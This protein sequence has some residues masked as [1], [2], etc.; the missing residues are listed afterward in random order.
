MEAAKVKSMSITRGEKLVRDEEPLDWERFPYIELVESQLF[1]SVCTRPNIAQAVGV[2]ARYMSAPTE[3][4][5][6]EG[7][8]RSGALFGHDDH[9]RLDLREWGPG[10]KS[11]LRCRLCGRR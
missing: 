9:M 7:G 4:H 11:L 3:A 5:A 1:F 10:V 8:A 6:L 2:L